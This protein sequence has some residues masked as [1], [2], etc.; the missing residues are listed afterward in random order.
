[1][2]KMR[3]SSYYLVDYFLMWGPF[4]SNISSAVLSSNAPKIPLSPAK[5][6]AQSAFYGG[7]VDLSG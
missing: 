1:M 4:P 6:P 5:T 3:I 7:G 2:S